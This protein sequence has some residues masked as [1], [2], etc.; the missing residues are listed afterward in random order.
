MKKTKSILGKTKLWRRYGL[1]LD[2]LGHMKRIVALAIAFTVLAAIFEGFGVGFLMSFLQ[3]L[4]QPDD[5]AVRTGI[6]FIDVW[7]LGANEPASDRIYRVSIFVL[8][9]T[10]V[11]TGFFYLGRIYSG[12][13]QTELVYRLQMRIFEQIQALSQSFFTKS[14][15][16]ALVN[17]MTTEVTQLKQVIDVISMSIAKGS[18]LVA[19]FVSMLVLSWQLTIISIAL[20]VLA[21]VALS[22]LLRRVRGS[23]FAVTE[24]NSWYTSVSLEVLSGIKTVQAFVAQDFER[25]RVRSSSRKLKEAETKRV[26][27]SS[28]IAPISEAISTSILILMLLFAFAFLIPNGSL[29]VASLLTF[30]FVLF[31]IIPIVRII[32]NNLARVSS[33]QGSIENIKELLRTTNKPYIYSGTKK[34]EGIN[35]AIEFQLVDFAYEKNNP[36]LQDINLIIDKGS[37]TALVGGSGAGKTTLADLIPRFYEAQQGTIAIDGTEIDFFD[38]H[39]LRGKMAIVSQDTFIFNTSVRNNLAYGL[40]EVSDEEIWEAA[41]LANAWDFIQDLPEGMNT[42]LGDRGTR[43]SGGQRQRIAIARAILRNP[44][45]LI[46]DEATSALDSVTEK[47]IQKSLENLVKGKTVISIAHRLSTIA[48]ADK[49]VVMEQGRI[50]EQGSYQELLKQK[51]AL[52][53]YHR[54]QYEQKE[55]RNGLSLAEM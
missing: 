21:A 43:L 9:T 20:F 11:R 25:Q 23:S 18:I 22:N 35:K 7:F 15:S 27:Y 40:K 46:L 12:F 30:L 3:S 2:E 33:F 31:R 24:A 16:G 54:T 4:V 50:V 13:A 38:L 26:V 1:L 19:Y 44:D 14:R 10:L 55:S 8:V 6:E 32:S 29:S 49:V 52:W 41:K 5:E 39:S 47:L 53:Q 28:S 45:I 34:F 48:K 51:G 36:V 42:Q 37:M 17:T